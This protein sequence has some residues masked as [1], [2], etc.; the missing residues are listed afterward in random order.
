MQVCHPG[1]KLHVSFSSI[2]SVLHAVLLTLLLLPLQYPGI[3]FCELI[4]LPRHAYESL[5]AGLCC[6]SCFS[7]LTILFH[8]SHVFFFFLDCSPQTFGI[9]LCQ[10]I[11]NDRANR[12]LQE[13]VKSSRR[14]CV[15]VEETVTNFRAQM[16]KRSPLGR[17]CLVPYEVFH[18]EPLSPDFPD[19]NSSWSQRR[20]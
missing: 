14:L 5:A 12:Q 6:P 3:L 8:V 19:H 10:V 9:P 16:Q 20:V 1:L 7:L 11:A 18:E 2:E 15:E 4:I 17:G 13:T